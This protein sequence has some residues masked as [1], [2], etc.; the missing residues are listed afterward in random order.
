[1]K[2]MTFSH[3]SDAAAKISTGLKKL[4]QKV[5]RRS[6][7]LVG[8]TKHHV[9]NSKHLAEELQKVIIEEEDILNSHDVVSL[10]TN[11]LV[12]Q[13]LEIVKTRLEN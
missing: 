11:T 1:M 6:R 9:Q 8:K 5:V 7:G 12:D 3:P 10:F 4:S 2:L 13:V